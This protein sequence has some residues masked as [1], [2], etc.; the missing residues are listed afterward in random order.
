MEWGGNS[1]ENT[2]EMGLSQSDD[3]HLYFLG[4]PV[5]PPKSP[6]CPFFPAT[7]PVPSHC[8]SPVP[9]GSARAAGAGSVTGLGEQGRPGRPGTG[10]GKRR[11]IELYAYKIHKVFTLQT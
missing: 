2:P 8:S 7:V 1:T 11:V 6:R 9:G 4:H 10:R 3:P 5:P